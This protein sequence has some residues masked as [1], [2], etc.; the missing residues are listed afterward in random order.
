[1]EHTSEISIKD[2]PF[3]SWAEALEECD[4]ESVSLS[5][6]PIHESWT[7]IFRPKALQMLTDKLVADTKAGLTIFPYPDLM[8][9]AFEMSKSDVR[10]VIVGQDPYHGTDVT[11]G[12]PQAMGLSFSVPHGMKIPPSL[13]NI[14][15]N[16]HKFGHLR[17]IPKHGNLERLQRQGVLFL[18]SALSVIQADA[19]SHQTLWKPFTTTVIQSLN[20]KDIKFVLWGKPAME[21]GSFLT[22]SPKICSSHPSGL[23]CYKPCGSYPAFMDLDF[24]KDLGIDWNVL[25]E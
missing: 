9:K 23:S 13:V 12:V 7:K 22:K 25:L 19:N 21:K 11:T 18:N 15:S 17:D 1:M 24:A 16:L 5:N 2:Y 6:L 8:F 4:P 10:V 3:I 14:Y 20:S